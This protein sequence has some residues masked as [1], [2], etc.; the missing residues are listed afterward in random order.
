M[1]KEIRPVYG[2]TCCC[3]GCCGSA[4]FKTAATASAEMESPYFFAAVVVSAWYGGEARG[5]QLPLAGF[6]QYF[7]PN[8][9]RPLVIFTNL[10]KNLVTTSFYLRL[11]VLKQQ[12]RQNFAASHVRARRSADQFDNR[13]AALCQAAL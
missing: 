4:G 3:T 12:L 8:R 5:F 11:F 9:F 7:N 1:L 2:L 10:R 13:V 6:A